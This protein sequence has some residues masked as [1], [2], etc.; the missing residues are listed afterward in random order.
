MVSVMFDPRIG[1]GKSDVNHLNNP[2]PP[3]PSTY[4]VTCANYAN[5]R[6]VLLRGERREE[7]PRN[8]INSMTA[9]SVALN[10]PNLS[11][12]AVYQKQLELDRKKPLISINIK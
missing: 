1:N 9:G 12:S 10:G 5:Y 2:T 6:S 3:T 7:R 4:F 8:L 11:F